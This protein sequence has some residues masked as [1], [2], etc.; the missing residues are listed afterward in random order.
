MERITKAAAVYGIGDALNQRAFLVSYCKQKK[1]AFRDIAIYTDKYWW[2]FEGIGFK[3]MILRPKKGELVPYRNFGLFDLPKTYN[4][5]ELD[6]CI[7]KNAQIDYSFETCVP[8][9]E[10]KLPRLNLPEKFITFNTGCGQLSNIYHN[11]DFFCLKSWPT[12]YWEEFVAKI[13]IPC[14]QL[15]SGYTCTPVKGAALNLIDQLTLKQSA[16]V[17]RRGLFHIDMEGGL[18]ILNQ[19][20]GKR[21]V[22]LFGPTAVQNQGREFNMN[23]CSN[24]C[25]PCYEWG[26]RTGRLFAS[27]S[28]LICG[29]RCMRELKPDFV[30]EAIKKSVWLEY[31]PPIENKYMEVI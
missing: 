6:K 29:H 24:S 21:S 1:I 20:L 22:V 13:G 30:I 15:G 19:H 10:F 2:M 5:E 12:E 27:K 26:G 11:Q 25:P 14:V 4:D 28:M 31:C 9:P 3:R 17:M 16:E 7:A 8:F 23:L 18:V